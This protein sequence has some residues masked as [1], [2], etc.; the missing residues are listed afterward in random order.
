LAVCSHWTLATGF[1]EL[2]CGNK[3]LESIGGDLNLG[4]TVEAKLDGVLIT[5]EEIGDRAAGPSKREALK[6]FAD[7]EQPQNG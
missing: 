6:I 5:G 4:V 3:D 2:D 1:R 7:V